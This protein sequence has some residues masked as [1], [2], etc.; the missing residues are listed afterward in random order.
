MSGS[1]RRAYALGVQMI[2]QNPMASLNPRMRVLDII[3]E[4]PVVHGIVRG[5][6][7]GGVRGVR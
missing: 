4:A 3:G 7:K 6:A 5:F 2:F 1:E